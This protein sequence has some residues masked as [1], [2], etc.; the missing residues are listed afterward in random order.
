MFQVMLSE[1]LRR[2]PDF[3]I[4]GDVVRFKDAGDVY[5]IRSLPV[6]FTPGPREG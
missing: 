5:A 4:S 2:L 3:T 6:T 1:V